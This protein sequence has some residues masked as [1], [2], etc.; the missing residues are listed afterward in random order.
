MTVIQT[1]PFYLMRHGETVANVEGYVA[2]QIDTPLTQKGREQAK[3]TQ[4]ILTSLSLKPKLI[5]HS[6]LSRSRDTAAIINESFRLPMREQASIA[7]RNLGDWAKI[8]LKEWFRRWN[9]GLQ[10]PNGETSDAFK[11]RVMI[12]IAEA[13]ILSKSPVLIVTHAGVLRTFMSH[14]GFKADYADNCALFSFT[15]NN[16]ESALPWKIEHI[17]PAG[18]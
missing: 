12:G 13:L 5:V 7:E 18:P 2:G 16:Q 8:S 1:K 14:Y 3:R 6:N 4:S 9:E 17:I 11:E 15:P 10:P